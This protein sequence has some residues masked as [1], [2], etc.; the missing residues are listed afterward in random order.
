VYATDGDETLGGS[1]LDLCLYNII[2]NQVT[3]ILI[4][5][6]TLTLSYSLPYFHLHHYLI[7]KESEF[8]PLL[9]PTLVVQLIKISTFSA[10]LNPHDR[11]SAIL[12]LCVYAHRLLG[13]DSV[14]AALSAETSRDR[15][16]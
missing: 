13:R 10:L 14:G 5:L 8:R 1:D 9:R 3:L 4:L 7:L 12:S 6:G 16:S 11:P 15:N 2:K